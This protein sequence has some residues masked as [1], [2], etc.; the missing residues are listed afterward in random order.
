[1]SDLKA[2]VVGTGGAARLH[3]E[4]YA[5]CPHTQPIAVVSHSPERAA[6]LAAEFA[7]RAYTSVEEMLKGER[8]DVVS[9]ATLEWD[10]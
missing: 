8:P 10:H 1:M 9:V 2:A 5:K 7:I 6:A 4:A 3:L